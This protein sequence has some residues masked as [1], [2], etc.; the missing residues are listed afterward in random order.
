M[1]S[2][3]IHEDFLLGSAT[4]RSLY[5]SVARDLAVIDFHSHLSADALAEDRRFPDITAL[6]LDGDHYKWRAMRANGIDER[7]VSGDAPPRERF[8]AWAQTVPFTLRNPL[9]HWTHLEL[10]HPFGIRD[11]L[12]G[13]DTAE[14]IWQEANARLAEPQ[15]SARG[16]ARQFRVQVLCTT[17]DPADDL[18]AHRRLRDD[19]SCPIAVFPTFRPDRVFRV[20]EVADWNSWVDK[21]GVAANVDIQSYDDLMSALERRADAF[22]ELGCRL[23]DHG[24]AKPFADGIWQGVVRSGF[25]ALRSGRELAPERLR[26]LQ[27]AL[28]QDL[29]ALYHAR[30]W[31]TQLHLGALRD[32]STRLRQRLGR[33]SGGD[34]IGDFRP[35]R[36]LAR[37]WDRLETAGRL[38]RMIVYNS[39]PADNE[40]LAAL[41]GVFQEGSVPGKIQ[42]GAAWWFLDQR[43]GIRRHLDAVSNMG[44]LSRF[45]GMVADS[46]S[47]LSWS[48]HDY[49]RR[50]LCDVIGADVEAGLLPRD[51]GQLGALVRAICHDNARDYL[52]FPR[53]A[54]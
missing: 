33:D 15:F 8:Q 49:F 42:H 11:R 44:L 53:S 5:H 25:K 38:G 22:H 32:A 18:A 35:V 40:A 26:I 6:W 13:P 3:F 48:R 14:G 51:E 41:I 19:A 1:D 45:V 10:A 20:E 46:R 21:L 34:T 43:D 50:V 24:M 28:L 9:Y 39:N 29:C 30:G 36:P 7:L 31:T 12:L 4:A 52:G 37:L 47:F 16:L 54:A 17:D 2:P 23:S 27:A